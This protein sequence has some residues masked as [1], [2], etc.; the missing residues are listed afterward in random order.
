MTLKIEVK[1]LKYKEVEEEVLGIDNA[2]K[3][4][5]IRKLWKEKTRL[6][7]ENNK[8]KKIIANFYNQRSQ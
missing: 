8:L 5:F 2:A 6:K 1:D 4:H 7:R 3:V